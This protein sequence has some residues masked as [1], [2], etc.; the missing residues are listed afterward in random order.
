MLVTFRMSPRT[1]AKRV[2]GINGVC[3]IRLCD[4]LHDPKDVKTPIVSSVGLGE[5]MRYNV[6]KPFTIVPIHKPHVKTIILGGR[7]LIFMNTSI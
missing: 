2:K 6:A 1:N 7:Y 3:M 4:V 5:G